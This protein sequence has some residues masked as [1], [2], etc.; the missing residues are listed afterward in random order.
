M[1]PVKLGQII[2]ELRTNRNMSQTTLANNIC[3]IKQLIRYEKGLS[4]PSL[5]TMDL[6]S[7]RLGVNISKY[8]EYFE[9]SDPIMIYELFEQLVDLHMLRKHEELLKLIERIEKSC[10]IGNN[11][12]KKISY[13][14]Y[15]ALA[16]ISKDYKTYY[17][18]LLTLLSN[19]NIHEGNLESLLDSFL[20]PLDCKIISSI[21]VIHLSMN[22][23]DKCI[24]L[25]TKLTDK[26]L[27][28][29]RLF[30]LKL[31]LPIIYNLAKI[32]YDQKNYLNCLDYCNK[33]IEL[34]RE[35][36]SIF[37]LG[38]FYVSMANCYEALGDQALA[39]KYY[40]YYIYYFEMQGLENEIAN[41][42]TK[43]NKTYDN[44]YF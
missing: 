11:H 21:A 34:L 5:Y 23:S 3:S 19:S 24:R 12:N 30:D 15:I 9:Y 33:G 29:Y 7:T 10:E 13:Y 25:L 1:N 36:K 14:K 26:L 39:K 42:K 31:I 40:G 17:P 22:E 18:K 20:E 32:T 6:I 38:E 43:L 27:D 4:Y 8:F 28:E 41:D 16:H 2:Y 35:Q 37:I 44:A